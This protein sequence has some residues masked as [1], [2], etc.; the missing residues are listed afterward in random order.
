[1]FWTNR[2][3]PWIALSVVIAMILGYFA[4]SAQQD[5]EKSFAAQEAVIKSL[6]RFKRSYLALLPANI[7]WEK[8]FPAIT[9]DLDLLSL[10]RM[11]DLTRYGLEGEPDKVSEGAQ[12][13][14]KQDKHIF[15]LHKVCIK[16]DGRGLLVSN[17]SLD[18]LLTGTNDL[19]SKPFFSAS[20]L[21]L[22]KN[23]ND[24]SL[25][26]HDACLYLRGEE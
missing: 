24:F 8:N 15:N 7:K 2:N 10:Y 26:I 1:M 4:Y 23:D 22:K 9:P 25:V 11:V 18:A 13:Q 16:T 21:V 6:D 3:K 17:R 12:E 20:R 14:V 19:L 5:Y